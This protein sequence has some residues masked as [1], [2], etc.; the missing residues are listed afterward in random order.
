[1][2]LVGASHQFIRGPFVVAGII[3]GLVASFASIILFFPITYWLADMTV[4]LG[5]DFNL[6]EYFISN[7][8]QIS[9]M[10]IGSGLVLGTFSSYLAVKKYLKI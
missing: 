6:Y 8:F 2:R 5:T 4:L 10:L 7:F 1:M 3:Y 9:L